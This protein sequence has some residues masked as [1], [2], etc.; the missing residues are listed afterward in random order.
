MSGG[1]IYNVQPKA[2]QVKLAGIPIT[3]GKNICRFVPSYLFIN[4]IMNYSEANCNIID[5]IVTNP[6]SLQDVIQI[7]QNYLEEF[8]PKFKP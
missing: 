5:P 3:A 1:A 2:N 4:A 7:T 8:D 6:P